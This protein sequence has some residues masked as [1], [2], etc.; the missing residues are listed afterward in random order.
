[1]D[2][3]LDTLIARVAIR[4]L[5][6]TYARG[7]DRRDAALEASVFT[8]DGVV[9]LYTGDPAT[10]APIDTV[11]GRDALVAT[12][13]GLI[14]QYEATS[15]VNGQSS[16]RFVTADEA[17]GETYCTALHLQ[18]EGG[19]RYLVTMAIRYLD[20]FVRSDG[21]WAIAERRLVIDW[22]DRSLSTP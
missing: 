10:T 22:T 17:E 9:L 13:E 6:D 14:A 12:F 4:E 11:R 1:M 21:R 3:T 20:R 7:A 18:R 2:E 8:A 16:V 15:Y 5:V 19:E